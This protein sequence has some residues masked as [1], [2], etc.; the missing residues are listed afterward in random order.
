MLLVVAG[1]PWQKHGQVVAPARARYE[2]VSAAID[3][4]EGLE[5]SRLEL[6]RPGLTYTMDTID[7]LR[8]PDRE[9]FLVVGADVAARIGTWQRVDDL[10]NAVTLAIVDR[11]HDTPADAPAGWN[12]V[13]VSMPRLDISSTGLRARIA[14]GEPVD[15]LVPEPAVRVIRAQH[16][17]TAR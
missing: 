3:G 11:E 7:E 16:L 6:D 8:A 10:R 12:T 13:R 4:V 2:M 1:D 9:L 15:F 14:A 17:Y 5:A